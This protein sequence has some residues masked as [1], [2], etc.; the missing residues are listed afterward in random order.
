MYEL[1]LGFHPVAVVGK[2]VHMGRNSTQNNTKTQNTQ[3][4][5]QGIQ[6]KKTNKRII[7]KHKTVN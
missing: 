2:K 7:K 4:S 3:N 6:N 1:H 5:K